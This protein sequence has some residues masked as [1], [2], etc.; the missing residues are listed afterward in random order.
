MNKQKNKNRGFTLVEALVILFIA[1][2]ILV[3]SMPLITK[4]HRKISENAVHGKYICYIDADGHNHEEIY[5]DNTLIANRKATGNICIFT[6]PQ[7]ATYFMVQAVGGGG[8]GGGVG[9]ISYNRSETTLTTYFGREGANPWTSD[10]LTYYHSS[11]VANSWLKPP[12]E[13]SSLPSWLSVDNYNL[14]AGTFTVKV[15]G[16]KGGKGGDYTVNTL[17]ADGVTI[18]QHHYLGMD[19]EDDFPTPYEIGPIPI[20]W[21]NSYTITKTDGKNGVDGDSAVATESDPHP[22]PNVTDGSPGTLSSATVVVK[23]AAGNTINPYPVTVTSRSAR[24]GNK[25]FENA[26][27]TD[28]NNIPGDLDANANDQYKGIVTLTDDMDCKTV[29]QKKYWKYGAG[30][31]AGE[32]KSIFIPDLKKDIPITIGRGGIAGDNATGSSGEAG[33]STSF[34]DLVTALGGAGAVGNLQTAT[35]KVGQEPSVAPFS[36]HA[37]TGDLGG[38]SEFNAFNFLSSMSAASGILNTE[39]FGKGGNGGG[40]ISNCNDNLE[41]YYFNSN[42]ISETEVTCNDYD[43]HTSHYAVDYA[44]VPTAGNNGVLI[45]VW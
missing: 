7:K 33:T 24:G 31:K 6:P 21:E 26:N 10:P 27:G 25:A 41:K 32:Y 43:A 39:N 9:S 38:T 37:R 3:A 14:H 12:G 23:N 15:Y 45:I 28:H 16:T 19:G 36:N 8:G 18:V 35:Y 44:D 42:Y 20:K 13:R 30:G 22:Y 11:W 34:G 40:T 17:A 2:L 5:K 29:Y 1:T 4:K